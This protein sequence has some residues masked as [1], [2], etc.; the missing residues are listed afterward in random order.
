M[1]PT[2][3]L[4]NFSPPIFPCYESIERIQWQWPIQKAENE[5]KTASAQWVSGK[6]SRSNFLSQV[7]IS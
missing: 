3:P 4:E 7:S 6:R 1:A 2:P 5:G